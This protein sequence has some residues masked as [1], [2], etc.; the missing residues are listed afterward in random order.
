[1]LPYM[2]SAYTA[3]NQA[4]SSYIHEISANNPYLY[5]RNIYLQCRV[6]GYCH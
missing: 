5:S 3:A 4:I 6:D 2:K 1:M